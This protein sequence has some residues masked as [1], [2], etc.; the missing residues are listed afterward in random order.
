MKYSIFKRGV[1]LLMLVQCGLILAQSPRVVQ[2]LNNSEWKFFRD[3]VN[4]AQLI[5]FDDSQWLKISIPHDWNGGI[6]G[7]NSDVFTGSKMYQGTGWYR[8]KFKIGEEYEDKSIQ[9]KFEAAS[10][11]ADV[12]LN[13]LF[14]GK[15]K[16][17]Y[18]AFSFD[19]SNNI[20]FNKEN[21]LAV[22]V[23][24]ANDST[25]APW[26]KVPYGSFPKS[27]DYAVYG[28]IYRDVWIIITNK[29]KIESEFH[30]TSSVSEE[31][32][33]VNIKTTIRNKSKLEV[34][35]TLKTSILDSLGNEVKTTRTPLKIGA[36]ASVDLALKFILENPNLWSPAS[37]YIYKVK[38]EL[39]ADEQKIDEISSNLGFRWYTLRNGT[40]FKLNGNPLFLRGINRHQDREG[41][42]YAQT[43]EQH[44]EDVQLIKSLGFNFLRHAHY[45]CDEAVLEAC[46]KLG[47]MVWLEI[48]VSTCIASN[49][50]FLESSKSQLIE[51]ITEHY[52]HPCVI[53]WGLGNESDR[54]GASTEA[55][56]NYF[57]K[58]LN[59]AAHK[60]DSTRPTTGCNFGK[61]SNQAIPDI[62][63]PQDWSGWYSGNYH[64]YM[65]S[66]MIGEYGS[67]A[68]II[69]H[70]E[71]FRSSSSKQPWTQE[72][73]CNLHEYKVSIG[74]SIK[75]K[76]PG[77]LAWVAFDFATPRD[78]RAD[79][80][81][82]YMNQKGLVAHDHKTLKDV[83]Y[84]YQSFYTS[85]T[86]Q[87][88]VYIVS[89]SWEDRISKP[90][91]IDIWAYS[92][93]D[94]VV[95]Y[96]GNKTNSFG[97]RQRTAG[98]RNDTRFQ[99]N[100]VYVKDALLIAEGY[101]KGKVVA[102]DKITF[103]PFDP[104]GK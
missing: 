23:S 78:D 81:I 20:K 84:F 49:N 45:P 19:I 40:G 25:L 16:G 28:G 37:P 33:I 70:D 68:F 67:D 36:N 95:L 50:D 29:L 80:P 66:K 30:T 75:D 57:F 56:T 42:G 93:C 48:P 79:N 8:A 73:A 99:W 104:E 90:S 3:D 18:T 94:S 32:A 11:T 52:N 43:N 98:P 26:M 13:G 91:T 77:H 46:D 102:V 59:H 31:N 5:T 87:P 55:Y 83:A 63:A 7:V 76:F 35:A 6:D 64:E 97:S 65:P 82:P 86:T 51:M 96:N 89:H 21:V 71:N 69:S 92:N 72:Y 2:S 27:S 15:H 74:E 22:K 47:I 101:F 12:W 24:N 88:M 4:K 1:V 60:T 44:V 17:G 14:I 85:P 58:E 53:V 103:T 62:Y 39:F 34:N 54:S 38:S 61:A 9:L 41:V 100:A 10:Q